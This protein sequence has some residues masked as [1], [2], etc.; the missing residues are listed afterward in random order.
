MYLL[1]DPDLLRTLMLRTGTGASITIRELAEAAKVHPSLIGF[2]LKGR[3]RTTTET[4][5][6][7]IAQRLGVDLLVLWTPVG[8]STPVPTNEP[9]AV[10]A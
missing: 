10:S 2:L 9:S 7:A 8:R 5:A 6:K 1:I 4:T 3:Q